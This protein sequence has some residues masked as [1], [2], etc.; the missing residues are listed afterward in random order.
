MRMG[1]YMAGVALAF[2]GGAASAAS[3]VN[4][5]F[6]TGPTPGAFL[7][8]GTGDTSITGWTVS[9]GT[10][11]Y[12]GTYWTAQDGVRSID[13]AGNSP[14]ALSQSFATNIGQTYRITYWIGRNPDGGVNPRTGYIDVGGGQTQFLYSGSGTRA[15]MQW[16][17]EFFN[18][19]ATGATT[20]LTLAA[21][22]QTA[23]QFFGPAIDNIS[24]ALV[25]EPAAWALMIVGFGI[26]GGALR[27][28]GPRRAAL[29]Y[30]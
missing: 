27:R 26:V 9:A 2:S 22:P 30:A 21:D 12:I 8:L 23:G 5:S 4:G 1:G 15:D 25:P 18:F 14:G 28:N 29:H 6:E 19:T 17:Q 20:T 3:I 24:I 10:I 13:L 16:Q 7:T 11:D